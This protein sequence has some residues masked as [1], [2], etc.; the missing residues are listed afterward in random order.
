MSG[1]VMASSPES[2]WKWGGRARRIAMIWARSPDASFVPTMFS[3]SRASARV[4][5]A[6]MFEPVRPGTL[7]STTGRSPAA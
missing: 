7:Y 2:T 1:S 4:V 6:V 3:M 5:E